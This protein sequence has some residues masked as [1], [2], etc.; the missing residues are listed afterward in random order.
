MNGVLLI[1]AV[2]KKHRLG[3]Q[4]IIAVHKEVQRGANPFGMALQPLLL[5]ADGKPTI[6]SFF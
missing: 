4:Q 1:R 3:E 6:I 5:L 2:I